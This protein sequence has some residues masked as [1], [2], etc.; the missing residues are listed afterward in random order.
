[1]NASFP[2]ESQSGRRIPLAVKLAYSAF[3]A[4]LVPVYLASYGPTNF[5]Y[6][7]DVALLLTLA[8]IWLESPLLVSMCCVG[9]L[10]PQ[11]FWLVDFLCR[12]VGLKLTGLTDY[13][14]RP[15][16]TLF[17]RSLSLFH[18]WLPLLLLWLLRRLGYDRRAFA[19]WGILATALV[20]ISYFL[21]PA[22]GAAVADPN[23]PVN[24]DYV[25]GFSETEPQHWMNPRLYV[26]AYLAALWGVVFLPTHAILRRVASPA[27]ARTPTP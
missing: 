5:L 8:G 9:I 10:L 2:G 1:M 21:L 12:L 6:F 19:A 11:L 13:M 23:I 16:L 25:Y 20:A 14:F 24:V 26:A 7:C 22:P 27:G 17:A 15:T 4:V 3:V 18:G